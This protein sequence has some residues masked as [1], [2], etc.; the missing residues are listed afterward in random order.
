M[1]E[2]PDYSGRKQRQANK[3]PTFKA[4]VWKRKLEEVKG[5]RFRFHFG[6]SY[7]TSKTWMRRNFLWN[8]RQK[9]NVLSITICKETF[10]KACN[11]L[12]SGEAHTPINSKMKH[13][14]NQL[15]FKVMC[16]KILFLVLKFKDFLKNIFK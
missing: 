14:A 10:L 6:H 1:S 8:V 12:T 9:V 7:Q 5:Y 2:F 11:S 4:G 3:V 13:V 15:S 16:S